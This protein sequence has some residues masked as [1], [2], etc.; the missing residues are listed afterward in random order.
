MS[1]YCSLRR[2]CIL[3]RWKL[4]KCVAILACLT[5]LLGLWCDNYT[6]YL[7]RKMIQNLLKLGVKYSFFP[8]AN[9]RYKWNVWKILKEKDPYIYIL[10]KWAVNR[11]KNCIVS[12]GLESGKISKVLHLVQL[13]PL[14]THK[15]FYLSYSLILTFLLFFTF[16]F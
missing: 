15:H 11:K 4:Y 6:F 14:S 16:L 3:V 10:W 5:N 2:P 13:T 8:L 12:G 1:F 7:S 9:A